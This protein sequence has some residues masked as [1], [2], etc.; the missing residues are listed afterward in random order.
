MGPPSLRRF[1]VR[2]RVKAYPILRSSSMRAATAS[3]CLSS[4]ATS[5][6][7]AARMCLQG[8][9]MLGCLSIQ[10]S[11]LLQ[12]YA[13][14]TL[15]NLARRTWIWRLPF[16]AASRIS[17]PMCSPSRSQSVQI[18]STVARL[19]CSSIFLAM[20]FLSWGSVATQH[21][22]HYVSTR[23]GVLTSGMV[24]MMRASK[25]ASGGGCSQ[26]LKSGGNSAAV[27]WPLTA[28]MVT[29]EGPHGGPKSK[30]KV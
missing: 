5:R 2:N 18:T 3:T 23:M 14:S 19:A 6:R 28:V 7:A 25:R 8:E 20:F 16:L 22:G 21:R 29:S 12:T 26:F 10:Q 15:L 11:V 27:R 17:P 24:V 9:T 30:S 1:N 4:R 13:R